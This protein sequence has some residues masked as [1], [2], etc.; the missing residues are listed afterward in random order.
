M[1]WPRA[2]GRVTCRSCTGK[3]ALSASAAP[4]L[5]VRHYRARGT[6]AALRL[7]RKD[8]GTLCRQVLSRT[9]AG[10]VRTPMGSSNGE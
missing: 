2:S 9:L 8:K 6:C 4:V 7:N 5:A 10:A 1:T 3:P